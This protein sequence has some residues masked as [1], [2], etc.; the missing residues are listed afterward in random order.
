MDRATKILN[1]YLRVT[2]HISQQMRIHLGKVS[3]TFPQAMLLSVLDR[4][5][6]L[7][8][9]T[10]AQMTNSANSTVSG[11]VDRLAD[12]GLVRRRRSGSDRRVIYVET[13]E[14]YAQ[15]RSQAAVGLT[16]RLERLLSPMSGREQ[17]VL[18]QALE[19]LDA[20]L[21]AGAGD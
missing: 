11:I 9:G 5:G 7:P 21:Q 1:A 4:E 8:I 2:Q 6:P 15:L 12:M 20:A 19:R 16:E 10:L 14:E 3:L 18:L 13:T 17:D